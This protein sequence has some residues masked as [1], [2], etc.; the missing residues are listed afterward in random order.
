MK[1]TNPKK[2]VC[3][4]CKDT[5]FGTPRYIER[6]YKKNRGHNVYKHFLIDE[7]CWLFLEAKGLIDDVF[8]ESVDN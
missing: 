7:G 4:Y 1:L 3:Q 8:L 2:Q 5:I 6:P